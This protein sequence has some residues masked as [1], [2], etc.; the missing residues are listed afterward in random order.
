MS[1]FGVSAKD[2]GFVKRV[3]LR[4]DNPAEIDMKGADYDARTFTRHL[5]A[6]KE[7][8]HDAVIFRNVDDSIE[9]EARVVSTVYAVFHPGKVRCLERGTS[10]GAL[11][12]LLR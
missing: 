2:R 11:S 9:G 12:I 6:A 7:A 4:I 3:S 8:G 1:L 10:R 5:L